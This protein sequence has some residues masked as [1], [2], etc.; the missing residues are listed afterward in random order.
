MTDITYTQDKMFT[1]FY[2]ETEAGH[3]LYNQIAEQNNGVAAVLN[4]EASRVIYQIRAAGF[5]VAK[6]KKVT[7]SD[8]ELL[9]ELVA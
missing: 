8:S 9:A 2:P 1:R 3:N 4:F 5:K 6:A 7:M